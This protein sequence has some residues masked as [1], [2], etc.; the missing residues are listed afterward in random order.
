V[1]PTGN[2]KEGHR[3][4]DDAENRQIRPGWA[5]DRRREQAHDRQSGNHEHVLRHALFYA[6][7]GPPY[8]FRQ[9]V[10][11]GFACIARACRSCVPI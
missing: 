5:A 7:N 4:E 2:Q 9:V 3:A 6:G 1:L 10:L 11:P 8:A